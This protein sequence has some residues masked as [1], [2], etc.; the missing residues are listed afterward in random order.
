VQIKEYGYNKVLEPLIRDL[1]L[2]EKEGV[3]VQSLGFNVKGREDPDF[4]N[5]L[6]NLTDIKDHPTDRATLKVLFTFPERISDSTS[7]TAS[8]SSASSASPVEW[9][10]PFAIPNFSHDVELQLSAAN[11]A[12]AK[13]GTLMVISKGVKSEILDKLA[14]VISKI[15]V[16]PSKHQYESVATVLVAKHPCLREPGSAKGWYCWVFSL[17]FKMGN[18][19]Q[20][21]MAAGCPEVL[22]NKRK[23]GQTNS[24]AI[25]NLY[26]IVLIQIKVYFS[27]KVVI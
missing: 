26:Y 27:T 19:R 18:Y 20:R 10:N 2:L 23:R 15:T 17:K 16:Y 11:D 4:G 5:Q 24:K 7:E 14:D 12:F 8:L 21:L 1:E 9:P 22:V 13:D 3:F 6:C 25:K